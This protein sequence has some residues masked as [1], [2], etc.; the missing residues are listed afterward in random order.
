MFEPRAPGSA[1]AAS[2]VA[3]G[4]SAL[5][6]AR[7]RAAASAPIAN[8]GPPAAPE[9]VKPLFLGL[10]FV[11]GAVLFAHEVFAARMFALVHENSSHAFAIIVAKH[12]YGG[13]GGL[14]LGRFGRARGG[15][16]LCCRRGRF[17]LSRLTLRRL[18]RLSWLGRSRWPGL[19]IS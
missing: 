12:L 4:A 6:L 11:S 10:A 8:R 3:V 17:R 2:S 16:R 14:R 13:L 9:R 15:L 18:S 7:G 1:A 5:L 19:S